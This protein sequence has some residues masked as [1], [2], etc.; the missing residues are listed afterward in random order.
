[1]TISYYS[2]NQRLTRKGSLEEMSEQFM[3]HEEQPTNEEMI[4]SDETLEQLEIERLKEAGYIDENGELTP[5]YY[6]WA[7]Q[8]YDAQR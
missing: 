6:T 8:F 4:P 2:L 3:T 1:M 5:E 7:D